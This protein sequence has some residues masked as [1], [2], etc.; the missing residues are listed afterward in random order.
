MNAARVEAGSNPEFSCF[1]HCVPVPRFLFGCRGASDWSQQEL[2]GAIVPDVQ[3]TFPIRFL[4]IICY[5][6]GP[7]T[8]YL[9]YLYIYRYISLSVFR[10][11]VH[12]YCI[13]PS[14][15]VVHIKQLHSAEDVFKTQFTPYREVIN[16][17]GVPL[18]EN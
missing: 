15:C 14:S 1:C 10:V 5:P 12:V 13:F 11:S 18:L 6:S 16:D 8:L 4:Y 17:A 7:T 2:L 3:C 9:Q